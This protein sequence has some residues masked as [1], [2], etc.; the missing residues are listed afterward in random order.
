MSKSVIFFGHF[1]SN[2]QMSWFHGKL[3]NLI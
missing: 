2:V 1:N 3:N